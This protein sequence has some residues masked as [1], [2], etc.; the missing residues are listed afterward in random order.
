MRAPFAMALVAALTATAPAA[1]AATFAAPV[2]PATIEPGCDYGDTECLDPGRRHAGVDY[3]PD[4]STEPV[5]AAADGV[6]RIAAVAGSDASHDFGNVV[7]LEHALPGGGRVSTVYAHLREAPAVERGDCVP[8]RARLGIMGRTGAAANV[9]LHF[10]VKSEPRL[11][12]PYGY[13]AGDPADQGYFDPKDFVGRRTAEDVCAGEPEP[14]PVELP[15]ESDCTRGDPR[16]AFATPLRSG[17]ELRAAGR[18]RRLPARCRIELSLVRTAG[19]RCAY[20]RASKRRM[21]WRPCERPVWVG[22]GTTLRRGDLTRWSQRFRARVAPGRYVLRL[23]LI[24][25]LGR[26]HVPPGRSSIGFTLR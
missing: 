24:D 3:L 11:G 18:V 22:A 14:G 19:E 23:Q 12:P 21:E 25:R 2:E 4:D 6:V 9:H 5:L 7:V 15:I 17:R 13:T 26:I 16:A 8:R 20:W 1:S 10:E